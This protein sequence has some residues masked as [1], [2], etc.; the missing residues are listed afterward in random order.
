MRQPGRAAAIAGTEAKQAVSD[1]EPGT[2]NRYRMA[3]IASAER[4]KRYPRQAMDRGWQGKVEVRLVI[5]ENGRTRT[6]SIKTS[7]GYEVLDRQALDMVKKAKP[8]TPIPAA[9]RGRE[10]TIDIPVI[11]DLQTG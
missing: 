7:S 11:F 6:A 9:L 3:L 1:V 8:L 2:L 10:F 4:Y 5:G